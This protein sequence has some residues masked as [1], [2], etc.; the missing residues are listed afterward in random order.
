[1]KR[2]SA[3]FIIRE[4]QIKITVRYH[5][6]GENGLIDRWWTFWLSD[7]VRWYFI[8]I[9][10]CISLIMSNVEHLFMCF[11]AIWMSCLE[12]CLF[13]S[14][15]TIWLRCLLF[16]HWVVWAACIFW[17]LTLCQLFHLLLFSPILRVVF[18]LA[19]SFLCC[20]KAFKFN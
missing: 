6:I 15:P 13:K 19:Y 8:V 17:T 3:L 4:M 20:A 9:L 14:F 16:W 1:M 10:I 18:Y 11:L 7:G 2:C 12:K 5:L